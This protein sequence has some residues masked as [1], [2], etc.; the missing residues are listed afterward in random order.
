MKERLIEFL[1]YLGVGQNKFEKTAGLSIGFVSTLKGNPTT[2]SWNKI[3][4]AYPNLNL[5]WL[6][7]GEGK[8][9]NDDKPDENSETV[10]MSREV[11]EVIKNQSASLRTKDEQTAELI[12]MLKDEMSIRGNNAGGDTESDAVRGA[13]AR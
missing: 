6:K 5:D 10:S 7:T 8:M 13:V 2:K 11:W 4:A 1:A 9:L 3:A 12:A